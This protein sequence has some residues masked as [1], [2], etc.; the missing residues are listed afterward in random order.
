MEDAVGHKVF[1]KARNPACESAQ[2]TWK[3]VVERKDADAMKL[4]SKDA[5][6]NKVI[7]D[8]LGVIESVS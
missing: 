5:W 6:M 3:D 1:E 7:V 2:N 4:L 8:W